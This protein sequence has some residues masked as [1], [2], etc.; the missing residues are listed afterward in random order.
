M[1]RQL[2]FREDAQNV[3]RYASEVGLPVPDL[4]QAIILSYQD[5]PANPAS[6]AEVDQKLLAAQARAIQQLKVSSIKAIRLWYDPSERKFGDWTKI[7]TFATLAFSLLVVTIFTFSFN[8]AKGRLEEIGIFCRDAKYA[9]KVNQP[10]VV[11]NT[12]VQADE[13]I[14]GQDSNESTTSP[15]QNTDKNP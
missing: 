9:H 11:T 13:N 14:A 5:P 6:D 12:P 7:I 3:A 8:D 2:R 10:T 4:D 1:P 15:R